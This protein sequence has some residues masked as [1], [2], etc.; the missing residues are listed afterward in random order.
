MR[1]QQKRGSN[2]S[3]LAILRLALA[4]ALGFTGA[5]GCLHAPPL[6]IDDVWMMQQVSAR[7]HEFFPLEPHQVQGTPRPAGAVL[8][9]AIS[10][11]DCEGELGLMR[12]RFGLPAIVQVGT[13]FSIELLERNGGQLNP[14]LA[15]LLGKEVTAAAAQRC[16]R[17]AEVP[18]CHLLRVEP[19]A[20]TFQ[21]LAPLACPQEG[22]LVRTLYTA[23]LD[24][25][26][27]PPAGGYDLL[28]SSAASI[29]AGRTP[30]RA[31]R[32]VWLR[33]DDPKAIEQLRVAHLSDLHVGKGG[34]DKASLIL[35]R[36]HE[37]VSDVNR[38]M[39]DLVI[40][41]GDIVNSGQ[42]SQLYPI[43]EKVLGE[44]AA[45]VLVVLG[46]H[47]IEFMQ[48]GLRPVRRY[49]AGWA[50]FARTFHPFLHFSLSLGG[51][52]FVGFD[53][54]PAER[55]PRVLT[56]GLHPASVALLRSDILRAAERGR[57]GVIL[58]SHAPSRASTFTHVAPRS[59]GFFGRMRYGNTAFES[60]LVEAAARGQ[61]VLHLSGH[62]HW[63]DVFELDAKAQKFQRWPLEAL[64]PCPR[65]LRSRVALITTQAAGHSGLF[66]KAN[67]RGYGF[68]MLLLGG[69]HPELEVF[70]Y[71][72]TPRPST[73]CSHMGPHA[74]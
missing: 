6:P 49:G 25:P 14:P 58:F 66:S 1:P 19:A 64:S 40:V 16:L 28:V 69:A 38:L 34:R 29:A 26:L 36:L 47:D 71:G 56:R 22:C 62:T 18:G 31:L 10:A 37:I 9:A 65:P 13:E 44:L 51:Y 15:A 61:E 54:G 60:L 50:N 20:S 30:T 8:P 45:P 5:F 72:T 32:A 17:G 33:P 68:S 23:H 12:P 39:P 74:V 73:Q 46:N 7:Y 57:R 2:A 3:S 70:R 41:T 55:T 42:Q 63:S 48:R 4:C 35:S 27:L 59:V 24:S 21:R 43:A 52:D 53:S 67:A 11:S